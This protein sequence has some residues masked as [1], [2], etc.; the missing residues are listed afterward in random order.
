MEKKEEEDP[1]AWLSVVWNWNFTFH[2]NW[3]FTPDYNWN[4]TFV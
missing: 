2:Y 3:N 4:F 1:Y